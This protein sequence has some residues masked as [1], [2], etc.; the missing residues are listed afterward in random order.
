MGRLLATWQVDG[1]A[2]SGAPRN[3]WANGCNLSVTFTISVPMTRLKTDSR[4][5]M[6]RC[7]I[8]TTI[9]LSRSDVMFA[10]ITATRYVWL[11]FV[12][13]TCTWKRKYYLDPLCQATNISSIRY[14][15][16]EI[17]YWSARWSHICYLDAPCHKYYL[18][19]IFQVI[20]IMLTW[21]IWPHI[22]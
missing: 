5:A 13:D 22:I 15:T 19:L 11:T 14:V 18:N 2:R 8:L 4:N 10:D 1:H 3:T 7:N 9:V 21:Y 17:L 16:S 20:Y 6:K 12:I